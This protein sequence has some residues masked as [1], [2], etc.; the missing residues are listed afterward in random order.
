MKKLLFVLLALTVIGSL[1]TAQVTIGTWNRIGFIAYQKA[2]SADPV[3]KEQPGWGRIALQFSAK[4]ERA[5]MAVEV[6]VAPGTTGQNSTSFGLGDYC[7]LWAKPF[8]GV[9][10]DLGNGVFDALRGKVGSGSPISIWS[11]GDEDTLFMRF[12]MARSMFVA[13]TAVPNLYVGATVKGPTG[14]YGSSTLVKDAY[15]AMQVGAGYTIEG[16]GQARVQ[17][18]GDI[19]T[20]VNEYVQAGFALIGVVPGLTADASGLFYIDSDTL[21]QNVIAA[22]VAYSANGIGAQARTKVKLA[23]DALDLDAAFSGYLNYTMGQIVVGADLDLNSIAANGKKFS[24]VPRVA[25]NLPGGGNLVTGVQITKML[26][27]AGDITFG[28]PIVITY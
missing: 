18:V 21:S 17:Y 6:T 2:G 3:V 24:A 19:S 23:T 12:K 7:K 16:I 11:A 14:G 25:M 28:I 9:E 27:G 4:A 22:A 5:G 8:D 13:I 26:D 1:A 15:G 10:L 20:G